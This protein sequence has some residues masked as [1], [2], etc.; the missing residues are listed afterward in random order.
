MTVTVDKTAFYK[1]RNYINAAHY[2]FFEMDHRPAG[3]KKKILASHF[4][5]VLAQELPY[6]PEDTPP[7]EYDVVVAVEA[8]VEVPEGYGSYMKVPIRAVLKVK[9][10]V[11]S[12]DD[13]GLEIVSQ[14]IIAL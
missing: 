14:N 2:R 5:C 13:Y 8:E 9:L 6:L 4:V 10:T 11:V 1:L 3:E 7:G 12:Y